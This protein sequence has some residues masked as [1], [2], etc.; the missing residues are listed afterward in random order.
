MHLGILKCGTPPPEIV[1]KYGSYPDIFT[2]LFS[3]RGWRFSDYDVE[4]SVLP[5]DPLDADAW[6]VTGSR[7]GVYEDHPFIA[8]LEA[9]VRKVDALGVPLLGICFGHQIVAQALGG[10]VEKAQAGWGLGRQDYQ[11]EA[12]GTV[13]LS[14]WHQDQVITPPDGATTLATT[15]LCPHAGLVYPG[16]RMLTLQ[17]HPEFTRDITADF[18]NLRRGDPIY[19]PDRIAAATDSLSQP[20][21]TDKVVDF[22]A[23][24]LE[25]AVASARAA[26]RAVSNG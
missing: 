9:F 1:A 21:D 12:L 7:H 11:T 19:P 24:F 15:A 5:D 22:M 26:A 4:A 16:A 8:P 23:A 14:A 20:L 17:P 10:R 3:G 13:A 18:L 25:Q 2:S 6:L